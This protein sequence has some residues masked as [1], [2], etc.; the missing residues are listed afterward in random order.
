[1]TIRF[2]QTFWFLACHL[3]QLGRTTCSCLN[4][5]LFRCHRRD[6]TNKFTLRCHHRDAC[7]AALRKPPSTPTQ[8]CYQSA[9]RPCVRSSRRG[10]PNSLLSMPSGP[11]NISGRLARG[12]NGLRV[13]YQNVRGLR[14]KIENLYLAALDGDYDIYVLTETWIDDRITSMQLFGNSYPVYHSDRG[15]HLPPVNLMWIVHQA[16]KQFG[17]RLLRRRRITLLELFTSLQKNDLIALLRS[18]I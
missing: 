14:T 1:M 18:S 3:V 2:P 12:T 15:A 16:L 9:S 5:A 8:S 6:R 7:N 11:C 17:R 13:Y 10:L 4:E